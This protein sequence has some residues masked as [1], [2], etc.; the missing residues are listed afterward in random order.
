VSAADFRLFP[1]CAAPRAVF[2]NEI[3][4]LSERGAMLAAERAKF[5]SRRF[6]IGGGSRARRLPGSS[7]RARPQQGG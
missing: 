2:C 6:S 1:R 5:G 3:K 7:A 4:R